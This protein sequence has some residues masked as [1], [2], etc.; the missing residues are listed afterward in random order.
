VSRIL[1]ATIGSLGDIHPMIAIGLALKKRGHEVIF[2]TSSHYHDRLKQLDFSTRTLRPD[3]IKPDDKETLSKL[4]HLTKGTGMLIKDYIF[5]NIRDTYD[6]IKQFATGADAMVI[7]EMVYAARLVAE[8]V[9]KPW[10]FLALAPSSFFSIYDMPVL[11]GREFFSFLHNFGPGFNQLLVNLGKLGCA[12][13]PAP[14]Y[15]LRA[16]LGLPPQTNPI[17]SAKYSPYLV[18]AAFSSVIGRR[19]KDWPDNCVITGF[20]YHDSVPDLFLADKDSNEA[21]LKAFLAGGEAPVVFTLGSAAMFAPG[22]FYEESLAAMKLLK[23]RAIFLMGH[24][25][26]FKD[27]PETMLA[28]DYVPFQ[29]IFP[30]AAAIVHQGGIGTSAQALRFGKPTLCVPYSH[31]QPDNAARLEALGTSLTLSRKKYKAGMVAQML[32]KL[33]LQQSFA[34]RAS[35]VSRAIAAEDGAEKAADEIEKLILQNNKNSG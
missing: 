10:A 25:P 23:R 1:L 17:F 13:W 8:V 20:I 14:Y 18:L 9:N 24:N 5:A 33:L 19:Q 35:E 27:L 26:L 22:D 32:Q 29:N 31:D 11:P 3:T 28:L 34:Q 30:A 12:D 7:T 2:A 6:D 15:K 4:M 21:L 16:E